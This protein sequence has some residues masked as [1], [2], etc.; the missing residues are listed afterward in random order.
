M[1][2]ALTHRSF[3]AENPGSESNERLEFLGD[4]VVGLA[5]TGY[6]YGAYTDLP[7]GE[8]AKLRASVVNTTSLSLVARDM[9]L[10]ALL[11][12]GKGEDSSGGREKESILAD[13]FEAVMG[14]VFVDGGWEIARRTALDLLE[15]SILASARRPGGEDFKT[16]LQELTS[17]LNLSA[18]TYKLLASG[19]D[20]DRRFSAIALVDAD[21]Y[22]SGRGTSKK[23]AEQAAAEAAWGVLSVRRPLSPATSASEVPKDH[24]G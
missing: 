23:R 13:V 3:I 16:R 12:L 24:H 18:P 1:E 19:P 20:H 5:V 8:L 10:G 11:R 7:E 9:N 2:L 14:A 15:P 6:S 4:S 21:E 22:G 17:T